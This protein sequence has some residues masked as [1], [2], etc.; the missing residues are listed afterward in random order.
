[1]SR[2][3]LQRRVNIHTDTDGDVT[4]DWRDI[5]STPRGRKFGPTPCRADAQRALTEVQSC[6]PSEVYRIVTLS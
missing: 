2:Y 3:Q 4:G 5:V 1:M 6:N